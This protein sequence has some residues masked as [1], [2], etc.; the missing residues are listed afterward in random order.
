MDRQPFHIMKEWGG[1]KLRPLTAKC[2]NTWPS[3]LLAG[4]W[5]KNLFSEQTF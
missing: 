4:K 3:N 5:V 2:K 1:H